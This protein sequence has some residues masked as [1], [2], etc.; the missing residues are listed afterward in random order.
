ME[1]FEPLVCNTLK[2]LEPVHEESEC[3]LFARQVGA[4][5]QQFNTR[6]RSQAKLQIQHVLADVEF[7]T[8]QVTM[9]TQV[10]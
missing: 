2:S 7:S 5:L 4:T 10:K 8:N 6:Q 9:G 3:E 1:N